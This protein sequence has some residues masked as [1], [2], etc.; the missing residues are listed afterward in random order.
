EGFRFARRTAPVRYLL[1][2]VGTV[3]LVG[4][5]FTVLMPI[6]ADQVLHG[7]AWAMGLLVGATGV[8]ALIGSLALAARQSVRGLGT[9][10]WIAGVTF[11]C[12]LI[13]FAASR[14]LWLSF[15][16]LIPAGAGMMA[17]MGASNTLLQVMSPDRLRGRVMALYSMM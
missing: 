9:W 1:L 3:S 11:G 6:F 10:V 8:G 15:V 17:Q 2:L 12:S 13:F 5:P 14:H 16:L 4:M 7:G